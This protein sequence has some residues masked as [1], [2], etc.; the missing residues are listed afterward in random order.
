MKS[1]Q[2]K[3]PPYEGD[4]PY[5]YFA[6]A[7]ADEAKAVKILS[8]LL[9]RGCRVWYC[10]GAAGSSQE[11]LRRQ[12]RSG[13]AAM[14]VLYLSDAA[15]ADADTKSNVLVNQKFGRPI[16]CLDPDGTDRRLTMGLREDVP[17]VPLY[18]FRS[19]AEI[20]DAVVHAEGFSQEILGEQTY[21][22]PS[23]ALWFLFR[24]LTRFFL[25]L[26]VLLLAVGFVGVRWFH[27]FRA[28]DEV[29]FQDPAILAAVRDAVHGG[30]ITREMADGVSVL[31]FDEAPESWEELSLLP[32]LE[33]IELPQQ[34]VL[35]GAE[36]PPDGYVVELSG[37]KGA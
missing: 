8:M 24:N 18:R 16:L 13:G 34:A 26:T 6:F 11:L 1:W 10:F 3:L 25:V 9:R 17:H 12:T 7:E 32:S 31:R 30:T 2:K 20:E 21:T 22:G 15:C 19:E 5:L 36:L 28:P 14:T 4:E 35:D 23:P 27:W 33:R 29:V 37:G